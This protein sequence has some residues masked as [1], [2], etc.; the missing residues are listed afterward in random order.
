[1]AFLLGGYDLEM[2]TIKELLEERGDCVILDKHLSWSNALL[3]AYQQDLY[4]NPYK[5]IYG[6]ELQ[7]DIPLPGNYHRIDHHNDWNHMPSSLEQVAEVLGMTLNWHQQLVAANDKGYIPAMQAMGATK[8]EI[9]DIRKKDRKA[10]GVSN[11]EEELAEQSIDNN[12]SRHGSLLIVKSLTSRFSPICDRLFPYR[13][14]LIYTDE[15][16]IFFGDGKA[17]LVSALAADLNQGKVFHGGGD[18]GYLGAVKGVFSIFE[19]NQYVN[20]IKKEYGNQ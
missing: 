6:L 12:L 19:I 18:N 17:N 7:E 4:E 15:E 9:E 5:D 13:R 3:S 8:S 2:L 1:M 11:S 10:Q 20:K 14:L 16:W